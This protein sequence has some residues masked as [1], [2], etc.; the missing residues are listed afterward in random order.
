MSLLSR[1]SCGLCGTSQV[2][3]IP[4]LR[5]L[6]QSDPETLA[7]APPAPRLHPVRTFPSITSRPVENEFQTPKRSSSFPSTAEIGRRLN[8]WSWAPTA[9]TNE[10][11]MGPAA[12]LA[13]R[14]MATLFHLICSRTEAHVYS[15]GLTWLSSTY[16]KE[17]LE[18]EDI[19]AALEEA[20]RNHPEWKNSTSSLT[21]FVRDNAPQL[22]TMLV[23]MENEKLLDQFCDKGM[24][25]AMF[26]VKLVRTDRSIESTKENP[27]R[28]L[29][30]GSQIDIRDATS[31]FDYW[32]WQFFVPE[33][34]WTTF[35]H[36]P[37]GSKCELPFL[38][39]DEISRTD[40]SI[41]YKG[42]V[43]RDHVT[44]DLNGI[45]SLRQPLFR[46]A[47]QEGW[48]TSRFGGVESDA[49]C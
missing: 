17:L 22:F 9:T 21:A 46:T 24:G 32:Q 45:V 42:V 20:K 39:L 44:F 19:E 10:P 29:K 23:F 7:D 34:R 41:V 26:P 5:T 12:L 18:N 37:L 4:P 1:L 11:R 49:C 38:T 31:L 43:H 30:F 6:S 27:P 35:D 16:G 3:L 8:K 48:L 15:D 14:K 40:F 25:D 33:L 13:G 2:S 28:K 36:P 47:S